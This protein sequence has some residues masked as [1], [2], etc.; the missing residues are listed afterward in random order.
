M[1]R[2]TGGLHD[3]RPPSTRRADASAPD[4]P[5][6]PQLEQLREVWSR[7]GSD[8]PLWA[9]LSRPDKRGGRWDI[10]EFFATGQAEIDVQMRFLEAAGWPKRRVRALDFGCG[11]GRVSRALAAH[12]EHV[13]GLD[14]SASMVATAR[15]LNADRANLEF[16]ENASA[17]LE[18]IA[19]ASIDFV[20]SM[21]TLQ[22]IP[23]SLAH[24]YVEEFLRVLAPG[25][26]AVFQ[27]VAGADASLRG[28]M[29]ARLSNRWLNPLRR[30]AWRRQAVFE[31]HAL[32]EPAL[33]RMLARDERLRL[34][35]SLDD[36]AAGPGWRGWRWYVV[37]DGEMPVEVVAR[38]GHRV[39]ARAGDAHIGAPLIAGHAHDPHVEAALR[40][41]LAPGATFLDIGANIGVFTMLGA[42]LVGPSGR[43]VAVEPLAGNVALIERACR[44]N[45]YDH[46]QVI[47]AA[48]SDE[49][50][51]LELRTE[52][53][54]SNAATPA[55]SGPRLLGG[56]GVTLPSEAVV[57]DDALAGLDR[58]D[59]VKVDIA[60]M[61]PR[62]LRGLART[63]ERLRPVL[64][65]EF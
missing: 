49:A 42:H 20:Y 5:P 38:D 62:A 65:C 46:V 45:G 2:G 52:P 60:G 47:R 56:R 27:F 3:A 50:G 40:T 51:V 7:L 61:E 57:L 24:G 6:S 33:R 35:E 9:V 64:I 14:V 15:R 25:G 55:A 11:A 58:L 63:L 23:S 30:L 29:F 16:R 53:S 8:D 44:H 37:N 43:V 54:T 59:L 10:D 32:D 34:L 1:K 13:V 28:R 26:V 41:H 12:F 19:D 4:I 21:M 18:G 36:T 17:R 31:M 39:F 22:H 48:A